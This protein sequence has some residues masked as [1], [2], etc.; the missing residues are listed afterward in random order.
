MSDVYLQSY[1]ASRTVTGSRHL[2]VAGSESVLLDCGMFQGH[3]SESREK[4]RYIPVEPDAVVLS[5][6]HIDHS[7][8]LPT[9]ARQGWRGPIHATDATAELC[10]AML[11]DS[12]KI[13][14]SDARYLNKH[15]KEGELEIEPVYT[16]DDAKKALSMFETHT[17]NTE[18][19]VTSRMR[20]TFQDA[21]HIIGSAGILLEVSDGP[22]IYFTGDIG[23]RMY[24]ILDDPVAIPKCD[25]VLSECTYGTRDH[26]STDAVGDELR[27]EVMRIIHTKGKL[28]IP[29]FSVGRTQNIVY[30]LA[31]EWHA[32]R[33]PRIPVFVDSPLAD[34]ATDVFM[35]H[36]EM[37]DDDVEDFIYD[38]GRPFHPKNVRYT[39]SVQESKK[40]N[41]ADGPM[42]IIAGSGMCEGGRIL[43]HLKHAVEDSANTVMMVGWSAPNTLGRRITDKRSPIRIHGRSYDLKA[44]VTRIQA[45]S[46]HAGRS[47]LIDF[48]A[49]VR[50]MKAPIFLVHGDEDTAIAFSGTLRNE[51]HKQVIVPETY[52]KYPLARVGAAT[53]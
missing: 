24:P 35:N 36:P 1:G 28:L 50:D 38:G 19:K 11:M 52:A 13:A 16:Q 26:P 51:G 8:A 27:R 32:G 46:A 42:I 39:E 21:G 6:A 14:E 9:L 2:I 29:A 10:Q 41:H 25:V 43:H 12:A 31:Q 7:G 22:R 33:L 17:Y 3:R 44:R 18:F 23:R 20:A 5:H 15:R 49:P 48:L 53:A 45:Y 4:N 37:W 30:A 34:K 47:D 40:L